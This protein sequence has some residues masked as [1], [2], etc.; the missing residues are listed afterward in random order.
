MACFKPYHHSKLNAVRERTMEDRRAVLSC[1]QITSQYEYLSSHKCLI[2][3]F[4]LL[5]T[6]SQGFV[7]GDEIGKCVLDPVHGPVSR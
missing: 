2:Q 4:F 5:T 3:F 7:H 6:G 1:F